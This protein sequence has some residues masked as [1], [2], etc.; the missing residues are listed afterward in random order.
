MH[1][2]WCEHPVRLEGSSSVPGEL[3]KAVHADGSEL[4]A[5]GHVAAPVDFPLTGRN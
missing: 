4:G 2:R 5:D 1:C 3:R